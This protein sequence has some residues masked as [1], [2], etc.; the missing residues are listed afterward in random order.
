M[1]KRH[2]TISKIIDFFISKEEKVPLDHED[3][4]FT[5]ESPASSHIE[6]ASIFHMGVEQKPDEGRQDIAKMMEV[7][8]SFIDHPEDIDCFFR[9]EW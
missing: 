4:Y 1:I 8:Y 6:E 3:E 9:E 5:E 7:S 2:H